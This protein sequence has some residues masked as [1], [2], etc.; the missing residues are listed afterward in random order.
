MLIDRP[1]AIDRVQS[2]Y[3]VHPAVA[4]LGPRQC[5]KTTLAHII[6]DK[7]PEVSFFDLEKAV[8]QR[9]LETPEQT[10]SRLGGLVVI[11][12][13]QRQPQLFEALRVLLD[14]PDSETRFLLLGSASP[15]LIKRTSETLAGRIGLV[16]LA[17][18]DM[19]EIPPVQWQTLWQ[20]GGFP[21][22]FLA[23]DDSAS[24]L[25]R[26]N[27]IRT[28]LERDIPQLGITIPAES[29]RRFWR[30]IAHYNG[31]IWN[32]A[33]FARS[34]GTSERTARNYLDILQG[35]YMLR[36]LTPWHENLKKRQ[37]KSPKTYVRDTGLLHALLE[38]E[39]FDALSGHPK[40]GASFEGFVIEQI[41]SCLDTRSASF[42][43]THGGSELDLLVSIA[44][45]RYGFE[46]KYND[47]PGV[48]RSMRTAIQDLQLEH[49]WVVYPGNEDYELDESVSVLPI[50]MI[51]QRVQLLLA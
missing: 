43:A 17:G 35:A 30:M 41:L 42:W 38:L 25:W 2:A 36:V 32:A 51:P 49:L 28:F 3:R 7:E 40:I 33:E 29:L 1:I 44:G 34:M 10:L 4:L 13:V 45:K 15:S 12:E 47:A 20:R 31:H 11:D 48:T 39:S 24:A 19:N 14:R 6:S 37:V 5:G 9:R 26:E 21:R 16:D 8:D 22:S 23:P 50:W 46:C 27:F 18:F